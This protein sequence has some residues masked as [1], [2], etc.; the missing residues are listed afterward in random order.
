MWYYRCNNLKSRLSHS[1]AKTGVIGR[2]L[3][4][5][6]KLHR[7]WPGIRAQL[8]LHLPFF[9]AGAFA[10]RENSVALCCSVLSYVQVDQS[11]VISARVD[12]HDKTGANIGMAK[13][14]IPAPPLFWCP[15]PRTP[16]RSSRHRIR[17]IA[18]IFSP[19]RTYMAK[20]QGKATAVD[21]FVVNGPY[22]SRLLLPYSFGCSSPAP[23][24]PLPSCPLYMP[25]RNA[26]RISSG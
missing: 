9:E 20:E 7:G 17:K 23:I 16:F 26:A 4:A 14:A 19:K 21:F 11:P 3:C 15:A 18:T 22:C 25:A 6:A 24:S 13:C 1:R 5:F 10:Q 12:Q 8:R 2:C